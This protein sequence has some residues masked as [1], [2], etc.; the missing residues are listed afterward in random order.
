MSSM[1][2]TLSFTTEKEKAAD[3]AGTGQKRIESEAP[4]DTTNPHL[5]SCLCVQRAFRPSQELHWKITTGQ[6]EEPG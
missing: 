6:A 4:F 5:G 2:G 1:G 3:S